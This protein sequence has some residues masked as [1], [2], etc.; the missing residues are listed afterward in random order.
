MG[1]YLTT[2][3]IWEIQIIEDARKQNELRSNGFVKVFP[4]IYSPIE[5]RCT[6]ITLT[7]GN[8]YYITQTAR[9]SA[10]PA[11]F[12]AVIFQYS[13]VGVKGLQLCGL[14][15]HRACEDQYCDIKQ[16]EYN[17]I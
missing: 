2:G 13:A 8:T 3:H 16:C 6:G 4:D 1:G 11:S 7:Y 9:D 15:V 12:L 5:S 14:S 17:T 10:F